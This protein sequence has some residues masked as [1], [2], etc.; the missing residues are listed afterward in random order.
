MRFFI[1][2]FAL[3]SFGGKQ[4]IFHGVSNIGNFVWV[5]AKDTLNNIYQS[6]DMGNHWIETGVKESGHFFPLW[7]IEFVDYSNGWATGALGI[8]YH[9]SNGGHTWERQDYGSTKFFTRIKFKNDEEGW[10]V[11]G[12]MIYAKTSDGGGDWEIGFVPSPLATDLY[13]VS[14]P[15]DSLVIVVGG[16]ATLNP[17]GQGMIARTEDWGNTWDVVDTSSLYDFFDVF[18]IDSTMGFVAGGTDTLPYTPILLHSLDLGKHWEEIPLPDEAHSLRAICFPDPEHGWAVG[19]LGTVIFSNDGGK[20]WELKELPTEKTLFDVE[21]ADVNRGVIVGDS[22]IVFVTEDGG[23]TWQL[24]SPVGV[25]ET[26]SIRQDEKIRIASIFKDQIELGGLPSISHFYLIG[27]NGEVLKSGRLKGPQGSISLREL[28]QGLIFLKITG[29][30][31][32][33][34]FIHIATQG[35]M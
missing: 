5:S 13:G 17:G 26:P 9:S 6:S 24:K 4:R 35:K 19:E 31:S 29:E 14:F 15:R 11:G 20:N 32:I 8:I 7:D 16:V 3:F 22:G 27:T 18:F 21:F 28:P 12:D 10:A 34:P 2:L 1:I 23:S 30:S 25:Q 33:F